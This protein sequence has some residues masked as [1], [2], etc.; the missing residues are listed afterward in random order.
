MQNAEKVQKQIERLTA[1]TPRNFRPLCGLVLGT[2]LGSVVEALENPVFIPYGDLPDY[3]LSTVDS[4]KGQFCLGTLRGIPVILQ[5]GRCHLYEGR[6][7]EEVVNGVRIMAGLGIHSLI[8]TNAAGSLNP[9][10]P[11]G[12]LM[13]IDDHINMTG[14]S[15]LTGPNEDS[16]GPRFPDMSRVYNPELIRVFELAALVR[17]APL[18]RGVYLGIQGPQ[19]ETRAETRAFRLLGADAV[20]MSTVLEAIAARHMGV[21]VC[22]ISCLSNQNLPDAMDEVTLEEIIASAERCSNSLAA[23]IHD[24]MPHVAELS[25]ENRPRTRLAAD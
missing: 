24:S 2:G 20:G 15:P 14:Q 6:T 22:G 16:F 3:P 4:H 10:F 25:L 18:H 13:V 9:L 1:K 5:Q 12:S 11:A 7:P 17:G 21:S 19:L 23:L 8:L